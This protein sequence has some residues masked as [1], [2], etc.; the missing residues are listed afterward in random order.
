MWHQDQGSIIWKGVGQGYGAQCISCV[1]S[2]GH[3]LGG[4]VRFTMR[5]NAVLLHTPVRLVCFFVQ[6]QQGYLLGSSSVLEATS[7][8]EMALTCHDGSTYKQLHPHDVPA[9]PCLQ[10]HCLLQVSQAV[11]AGGCLHPGGAQGL[12]CTPPGGQ[13]QGRP[14]THVA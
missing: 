11:R 9:L 13:G 6:A 10:D 1:A 12:K 14:R 7:C 8:H 5:D 3:T 2:H 4:C